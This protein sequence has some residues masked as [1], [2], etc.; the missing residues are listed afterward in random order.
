MLYTAQANTICFTGCLRWDVAEG[1]RDYLVPHL[2]L[3]LIHAD[4]DTGAGLRRHGTDLYLLGDTHGTMCRF[5]LQDQLRTW[6]PRYWAIILQDELLRYTLKLI[7]DDSVI[8]ILFV[9]EL[10]AILG[11]Y[12][13]QKKAT[14]VGLI[15]SIAVAVIGHRSRY[16]RFILQQAIIYDWFVFW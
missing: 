4:L 7:I 14:A 2:G 15:D 9:H 5:W 1:V 8:F 11:K 6:W 3:E 13:L 12:G 10:V 16:R